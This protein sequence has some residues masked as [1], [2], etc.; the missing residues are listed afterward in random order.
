MYHRDHNPPHFHAI[1]GD[2]EALFRIADLGIEK[3]SLPGP[4]EQ[5]VRAWASNHQPALAFN[6]VLAI[7]SMPIRNIP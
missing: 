2:D 3:G 4:A 7:A 1:Q 6:W 5:A